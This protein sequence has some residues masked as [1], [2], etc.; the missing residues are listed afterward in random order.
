M[1]R[2]ADTLLAQGEV[3]ALRT[4]QHWLAPLVESR[5]P[6]LIFIAAIVILI[7]DSGL[8]GT[9][10]DVLGYVVLAGVIVGALWT[11]IVFW[12]WSA[13]D[14][15]VTSRRV[16]KV[17]GI[18]NK[19]S[20]DSSL[21]KI[22]DAVLDQ[23]IV[24]RMLGFGD[25]DI[26]TANE[27]SVDRYRWLNDA[28]GFKKTMLD[29]KNNL[30]MDMRHQPSPPLRTPDPVPAGGGQAA[31]APTVAAPAASSGAAVSADEVTATLA[32]LADLRDR[33]AITAEDY[34]TKKADLLGRL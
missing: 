22:N 7:V 14:Y 30:E 15:L 28:P 33:G 23:N 18:F 25:L 11:A 24:G 27:D 1:T 12:R 2:Y 26:L 34:E 20:A 6:I 10:H 8:T 29:Q 4:R 32:R 5:Y 9:I 31:P 13:E 21:E 17:E 16:I 3:V 19:H